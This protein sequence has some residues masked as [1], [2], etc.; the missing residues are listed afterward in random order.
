[1]E[2]N[3]EEISDME[4]TS[5]TERGF[6]NC[7]STSIANDTVQPEEIGHV[8]NS[9]DDNRPMLKPPKRSNDCCA[10]PTRKRKLIHDISKAINKLDEVVKT[11]NTNYPENEFD[12]FG[13]LVATQLKQMPLF[14]ALTCQ[15]QIQTLLRKKRFELLE[16]SQYFPVITVS[17]NPLSDGEYLAPSVATT[18]KQQE[19]E[20]EYMEESAD[21]LTATLNGFF[22]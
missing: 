10:P 3:K 5:E 1:M 12:I 8:E 13:K 22:K 21:I 6:S 15:D 9:E 4:V 19:E 20:P 16:H 17:A 2:N 18:D 11:N 7:A 14:D